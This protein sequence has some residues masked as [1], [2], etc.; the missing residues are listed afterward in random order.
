M[1]AVGHI[2][3]QDTQA[4][5]HLLSHLLNRV[6]RHNYE[7]QA[8]QHFVQNLHIIYRVKLLT[9]ATEEKKKK[10]SFEEDNLMIK[11]LFRTYDLHCK[12]NKQ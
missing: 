9:F 8:A 11:V 10:V 2:T 4:N 5:L 12:F 6:N 7:V 3:H 1:G